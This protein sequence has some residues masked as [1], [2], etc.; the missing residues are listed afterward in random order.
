MK[1]FRALV[2]IL[3]FAGSAGA[4]TKYVV[5]EGDTLWNIAEKFYG[6][7]AFWQFIWEKNASQVKNPHWI[8]PGQTLIVPSME[9][10]RASIKARGGWIEEKRVKKPIFSLEKQVFIPCV[11]E[12]LPE[13]YG[14]V[15]E[16]AFDP[17]KTIYST[18]DLL[19][20]RLRRSGVREGDVLLVFNVVEPEYK[21]PFDHR[22][23]GYYVENVGLVRV[24]G[25]KGDT[26]LAK[27]LRTSESI[28]SGYYV[29]K[30]VQPQP[31]YK[32]LPFQGSLRA[33]VV[34][35]ESGK[36]IASLGDVVVINA[37][38][39]AG[40]REGNLVYAV[41]SDWNHRVAELVVVKAEKRTSSCVVYKQYRSLELGT[42]V[43][44]G[45]DAGL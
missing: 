13:V 22:L 6:N 39:D 21:D 38:R 36:N 16:E 12:N 4:A 41:V 44:G 30:F 28:L 3:V 42:R 2:L 19:N 27:V 18:G 15:S 10:I 43:V 37:G 24:V 32:I 25:I 8:Y 1:L 34:V 33:R 20:I 11:V 40:L 35:L 31:I 29:T 26:A 17:E 7:A 5:K 14:M 45:E 9:E 23:L